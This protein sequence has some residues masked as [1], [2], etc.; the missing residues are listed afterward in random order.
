MKELSKEQ[1]EAICREYRDRKENEVP[2]E[3][4]EQMAAVYGISKGAV[5]EVLGKNGE[6]IKSICY[7]KVGRPRKKE[8]EVK[9]MARPKATI[10]KTV[11]E[12]VKEKKVYEE[13]KLEEI[14]K[15]EAEKTIMVDMKM[16]NIV[17][18]TKT[19]LFIPTKMIECA[20]EQIQLLREEIE[21]LK[22]LD[23]KIEELHLQMEYDF[24]EDIKSKLETYVQYLVWYVKFLGEDIEKCDWLA[25]LMQEIAYV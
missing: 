8:E 1:K 22:M 24:P 3:V 25:E 9:S 6:D 10:K 12:E 2:K 23:G 19:G 5:V 11:V 20:K 18:K 7:G 17:T 13:P 15:E 21:K 4:V 16:D 14:T